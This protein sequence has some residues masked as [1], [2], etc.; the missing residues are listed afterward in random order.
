MRKTYFKF[1]QKSK[2]KRYEL[3]GLLLVV[4]GILLLYGL[5]FPHHSGVVGLWLNRKLSYIVGFGRFIFP[6]AV[7]FAGII[8]IIRGTEAL[9]VKL[10]GMVGIIWVGTTFFSL[11]TPNAPDKNMGGLVGKYS[12]MF[13]VQALGRVG[14][15]LILM[16]FFLLILHWITQFSFSHFIKVIYTNICEDW[17]QWQDVRKAQKKKKGDRSVL[18]P[19]LQPVT[20]PPHQEAPR[21]VEAQREPSPATPSAKEPQRE[22][23]RVSSRKDAPHEKPAQSM[24]PSQKWVLPPIDLLDHRTTKDAIHKE[25][26]LVSRAAQLENAL[27]SFNIQA[28]VT[29]INPGP[30]ITR[31]DLKLSPGVKV[32]SIISL[33]NDLALTMKSSSIRIVAPIPGKAAVGIEIPN[34]NIALVGLRD[35]IG[36]E[37]FRTVNSKITMGLGKMTDGQVYC[38][39]LIPMPHLLIAGAT[40]SGKSVCIHSII[41]SILYKALPSEVKL[42]LIDPKRLELPV[43][44]GLPHLYDPSTSDEDV[45]VITNSKQASKTLESL[46]KV[47]EGRYEK[48]AKVSVRNIETYNKVMEKKGEPKEYYI[49]MVIDELADLMLI[50]SRDVEE[51]IQHLAQM[52]RAVGIHLILATQ[53]PSVDV[54]T[55]VIKAN[56]SARISFQVLSKVDSRVILD[57]QG[58]EDLLGRGDM[59]F[60]PPGEPKPV[61]LQGAFVSEKEVERVVDFYR[62]QGKPSYRDETVAKTTFT[63]SFEDEESFEELI[64]ALRLIKER[65]RVSQDLL[66]AHFGSSARAT[67]I[68]SLLEIKSFIRKPEGSNRWEILFDQVDSFLEENEKTVDSV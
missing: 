39:D 54:L 38:T 63:S 64:M 19:V 8:I 42:I 12:E 22:N 49:A 11:I 51:A 10:F 60:L 32:G 20:E 6:F 1:K 61:R 41:T 21:I 56:F 34:S 35:I 14:S 55:G 3:I 44:N 40:G 4:C 16:V 47:M 33:S 50:A 25:D 53:R 43:Y 66:K 2:K 59:L 28:K 62:K 67:N 52:S 68:L 48:F 27:N 9:A 30:I 46:V 65:R 31:Y 23:R 5:V 7:F 18:P 37:Q 36:S 26:E 24:L 15:F 29:D 57:L 58:A 45:K 17:K 13:L